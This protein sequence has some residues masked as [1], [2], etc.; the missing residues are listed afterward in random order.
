MKA[1]AIIKSASDLVGGDRAEAYGADPM[2]GLARI[3]LLWNGH[4]AIA[5]KATKQPLDECDVA[6][7]MNELK[8]A[9]AFTGP[10]KD[11]H[12]IDGVGWVAL[13]GEAAAVIAK[14]GAK[15]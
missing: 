6:W 8:H 2:P 4:L 15:I 7:M 5:G 3:A 12:Y 11:D 13:A 9:R 10:L 1:S 14:R